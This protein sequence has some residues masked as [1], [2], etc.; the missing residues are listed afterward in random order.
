MLG[1]VRAASRVRTG[2]GRIPDVDARRRAAAAAEPGAATCLG[3]G[4][5]VLSAL[6]PFIFLIVPRAAVE[7][8]EKTAVF[9]YLNVR[10]WLSYATIHRW[11]GE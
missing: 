1:P 9:N 10:S 5:Q 2:H 6:A 4:I 3:T 11:H 7:D 8:A